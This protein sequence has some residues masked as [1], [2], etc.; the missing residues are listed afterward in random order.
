[1]ASKLAMLSGATLLPNLATHKEGAIHLPN[2]LRS[3]ELE[4]LR[5]IAVQG[6]HARA[7]RRLLDGELRAWLTPNSS[8]V[9]VARECLGK[10]ATPVRAVLFDK[11]SDTNWSVPWHQDRTIAV[12]ERCHV[13]GYGNW[14]LKA[15]V[16][17]VEPP[18]ELFERMKTMKVLLDPC[19]GDSGPILLAA[20]SH[21][22]GKIGAKDAQK[23]AEQLPTITCTGGAGDVWVLASNILHASRTSSS[24]SSRRLLH[25]DFCAEGLPAPLQWQ[26]V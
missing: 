11:T 4:G 17:H 16:Q 6:E 3:E 22:M 18:F 23:I 26:G 12:K 5:R 14:S 9:K 2:V 15:G 21:R 20:G 7:G 25:I 24:N 13:E 1:M 10:E 8:L 19:F